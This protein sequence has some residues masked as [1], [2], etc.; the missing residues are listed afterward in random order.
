[1][2]QENDLILECEALK[3]E[4]KEAEA[5]STRWEKSCHQAESSSQAK[6]EFLAHMSQEMRNPLQSIL[7][8]TEFL[9]DAHL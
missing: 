6:S 2:T 9:F 4:L 1:M 3:A 8:Q 5:R 7:G